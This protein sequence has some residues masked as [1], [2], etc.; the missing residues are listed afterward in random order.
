MLVTRETSTHRLVAAIILI[1]ATAAA[2]ASETI[3]VSVVAPDGSPVPNV[4]VFIDNYDADLGLASV[5]VQAVMDQRNRRFAPHVLV[6]QT[7]T[8]VEFPNSD[9]IA[10]HVYSFS[11]PNN[12]VLPLYKG[13]AHDPVLFEHPGIVTIGCNIHDEM[14]GYIV[15]VD[16]AIHAVTDENGNARLTLAVADGNYF[17]N[18]WSPRIRDAHENLVKRITD[19]AEAAD[20]LTFALQKRLRPSHQASWDSVQWNEY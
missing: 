2:A 17:V 11:K 14:L 6:V 20:G 1:T 7:G 12:F 4:A 10:H 16:T 3:D 13:I 15:V 18:I 9:D 8:A 5:G 19:P